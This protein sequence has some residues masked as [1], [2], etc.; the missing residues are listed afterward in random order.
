MWVGSLGFTLVSMEQEVEAKLC[1][2]FL[3]LNSCKLQRY[4]LEFSFPVLMSDA[5]CSFRFLV[6]AVVPIHN[7]TDYCAF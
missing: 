7:Y 2:C 5:H 6:L 4:Y 1:A 3:K